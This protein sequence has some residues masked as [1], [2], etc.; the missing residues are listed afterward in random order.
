MLACC[1]RAVLNRMCMMQAAF[2]C[3]RVAAAGPGCCCCC[4]APTY[5][6]HK[7][8][9]CM[10]AWTVEPWRRHRPHHAADGSFV[11]HW[12]LQQG[13]P[14]LRSSGGL[15][16]WGLPLQLSSSVLQRGNGSDRRG[17]PQSLLNLAPTRGAPAAFP[18][19]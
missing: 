8:T 5:V 15:S 19:L 3:S 6:V 9:I 10:E 4:C 11:P 7:P 13:G 16:S 17:R 12:V 2:C 1:Q 18:H 14:R